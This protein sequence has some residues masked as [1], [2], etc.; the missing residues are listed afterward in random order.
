[1][2]IGDYD[3]LDL[4]IVERLFADGRASYRTLAEHLDVAPSTVANRI[5]R[6]EAN[7]AIRGYRPEVAYEAFGISVTAIIH[8]KTNELVSETWPIDDVWPSLNGVLNRF[9][10]ETKTSDQS[11]SRWSVSPRLTT[12]YR[13]TGRYDWMTVWRFPDL[14][15]VSTT[16]RELQSLPGTIDTKTEIAFE[17][18]TETGLLSSGSPRIP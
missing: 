4:R 5:R 15:T 16:V 10:H 3:D 13:V 12:A 9:D 11:R 18:I 14:E 17:A 7:G 1:V 8:L 6:M 2:A